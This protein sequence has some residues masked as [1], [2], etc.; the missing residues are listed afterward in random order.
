MENKIARRARGRITFGSCC[1]ARLLN[2]GGTG[3]SAEAGDHVDVVTLVDLSLDPVP[4]R[5]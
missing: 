1:N 4:C 3:D 2:D 5:Q